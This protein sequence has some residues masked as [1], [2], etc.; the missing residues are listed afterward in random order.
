MKIADVV[1][2]FFKTL[3]KNN[4]ISHEMVAF[5]SD[6]K[7]CKNTFD[8]GYPLLKK[9]KGSGSLADQGKINGYSR[10]WVKEYIISG[11]KYIMCNDWYD[12]NAPKF[13]RWMENFS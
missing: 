8:L 11:E 2:D 13:K 12:R 10:Y 9:I 3:I 5:L 6:S 4:A 7:Y 1:R